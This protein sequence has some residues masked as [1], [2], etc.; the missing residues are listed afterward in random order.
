MLYSGI[1]ALLLKAFALKVQRA[2]NKYV[3]STFMYYH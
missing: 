3:E 1:P 2:C